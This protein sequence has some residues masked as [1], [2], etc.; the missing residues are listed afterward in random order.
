MAVMSALTREGLTAK[1]EEVRG[2]KRSTAT[3][4]GGFV[5]ERGRRTARCV[6]LHVHGAVA[7]GSTQEEDRAMKPRPGLTRQP[8][9][10]VEQMVPSLESAL[11]S[12]KQELPPVATAL[13][14]SK[15]RGTV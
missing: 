7:D 3:T 9:H 6:S 4:D 11:G 10:Q 13:L 12:E 14:G 1:G 15:T 8:T 2:T 5:D